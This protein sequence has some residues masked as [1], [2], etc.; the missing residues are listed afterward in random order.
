M[1]FSKCFVQNKTYYTYMLHVYNIF[2]THILCHLSH[3][4][5][6]KFIC[7]AKMWLSFRQACTSFWLLICNLVCFSAVLGCGFPKNESNCQRFGGDF[8][9]EA[10]WMFPKK[11]YPQ[12]IHLNRVFPFRGTPIFGNTHVEHPNTISKRHRLF[13][14]NLTLQR[15]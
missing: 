5:P 13:S 8:V 15:A 3:S 9:H 6:S 12:I 4:Y 11:W 14:M 7:I 10:M 2:N 1:F